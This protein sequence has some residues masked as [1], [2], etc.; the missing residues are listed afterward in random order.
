MGQLV[1]FRERSTRTP[2]QAGVARLERL[3]LTD[4]PLKVIWLYSLHIPTKAYFKQGANYFKLFSM[5]R[6]SE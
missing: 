1:E 4:K 3:Y 5:F 2:F 6:S